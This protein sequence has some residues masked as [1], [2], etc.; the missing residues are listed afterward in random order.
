M[1][2]TIAIMFLSPIN[3]IANYA[4]ILSLLCM[5]IYLHFDVI[6]RQLYNLVFVM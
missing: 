1:T 4:V 6:T 2:K 5:P 3:I